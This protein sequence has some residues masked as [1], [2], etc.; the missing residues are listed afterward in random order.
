M[1]V[2][3]LAFACAARAGTAAGDWGHFLVNKPRLFL[4]NPEGRAFAADIHVM[5][6]PAT[7]WNR[8]VIKARLTSPGGRILADGEQPLAGASCRLEAKAG[9]KGVYKLELDGQPAWVSS[10]LDQSVLWTGDPAGA[11]AFRDRMAPAFQCT[12]P[13]RWWFFVPAGVTRFSCKAQRSSEYMSQREDWGLFIITPRGQRIR[14]LWGQ[15]PHT[16]PKEYRQDMVAEVEVEPGAGGRFW[17]LEMGFADSHNYSKPNICLEGVP[18]YLARSPEEWFD[19]ATGSAPAAKLYD[20]EPFIQSARIEGIMKTNWPNLQHFSPCPSIGDPDGVSILGGGRFLL[21]N[22]EGRPLRFRLGTYLPRRGATDPERAEV[23]ATGPAG[24]ELFRETLPVLH[25]HGSDGQPSAI[26]D[27]G[28]NPA[29]FS[30][31]GAERWFAFTYPAVP[32][33]L[34]GAPGSG[35]WSRFRFSAAS[36]RNWYFLV[37]AGVREFSVRASAAGAED[38]LQL[39]IN[40]PDR[41]QALIYERAGERTV[42]V[43]EGL[44]GTIWH[45][46]P[47]AGSASCFPAE[48]GPARYQDLELT[49]DLKGV[50]P[51]LSPTWEQWFDPRLPRLPFERIA[52]D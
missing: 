3:L 6:W 22:P 11:H 9:E 41:T 23:A 21:W 27:I 12:V 42:R 2:A 37:P 15:P 28:T 33:V 32:T 19:P 44:D 34:A 7:N 17:A 51:Y 48:P 39:E 52:H 31:T 46:R 43:P 30:V 38:V 16:P 40:A 35:G 26:P 29:L 49:I 50:P 47:S 14:A 36:P 25:I 45:L 18:P 8:G 13:R 1:T 24:R 10:T 20:D 4:N 5:Q